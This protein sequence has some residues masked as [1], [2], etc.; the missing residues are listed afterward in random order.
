MENLMTSQRLTKGLN[1][2][3]NMLITSKV[4]IQKIVGLNMCH[5]GVR[6]RNLPLKLIMTAIW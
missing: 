3:V 2:L 1:E 4:Y 5:P 6:K